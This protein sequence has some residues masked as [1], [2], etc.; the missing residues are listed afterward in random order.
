MVMAWGFT[1]GSL[2]NPSSEVKARPDRQLA[3]T[4]RLGTPSLHHSEPSLSL[5]A[6]SEV[7]EQRHTPKSP[8]KQCQHPPGPWPGD[9][10]H[11]DMAGRAVCIPS[12]RTAAAQRR[13][14]GVSRRLR[15]SPR[16]H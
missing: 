10:S 8:T 3:P 6:P 16:T 12:V 15:L 2:R 1:L 11:G 5:A 13:R 7:P 4:P 9:R 14:G